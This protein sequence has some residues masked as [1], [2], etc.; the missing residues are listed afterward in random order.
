MR[1]LH[2]TS[3]LNIGGI[4]RYT[5]SLAAAMHQRGHQAVIASSGGQLEREARDRGIGHWNVPLRTSSELHP[6]VWSAERTLR[7]RLRAE[8]VDLLHAH[9]RVSQVIA[10]R[11]SRRL[12]IP[13]VTTWHGFFR[14]NLGRTLWPCTGDLTIAISEPVRQHLVKD[15]RVPEKLIRLIPNGVDVDYFARVPDPSALRAC[16]ERWGL[17]D[18]RPVIGG[19]GRLASG[20]VKGFDLLLKAAQLVQREVPDVQVLLVGDGPRRALLEEEAM[21]CGLRDRVHFIGAMEDIRPPL[22]VMDVFLFPVRWQ[23]GFGL[24]LIEAMAAGKPVVATGV[25]AVPTI[26]RHE[27]EGWLAAPEDP[28]SLAQGVVRLLNDRATADRL[29]RQAQVRIRESFRL[30]QM[31]ENVDVVY[32]ELVDT[33]QG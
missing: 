7:A 14:P 8:P 32:R 26:I 28:A 1:I 9:T 11:L 10:A 15:F 4:A 18:H 16:R 12:K 20:G 21:R 6:K 29:G 33:A 23:E 30:D 17:P 5:I 13:Y 19:I 22:A 27:R 24:S 3:H 2:I 31:V 25:G